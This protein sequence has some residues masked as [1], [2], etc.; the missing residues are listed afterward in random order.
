MVWRMNIEPH[1]TGQRHLVQLFGENYYLTAIRCPDGGLD[2]I[3]TVP[4][5]NDPAMS[6]ERMAVETI[7]AKLSAMTREM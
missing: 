5:E 4:R 2:F 7:C 1:G 6:R 3:A